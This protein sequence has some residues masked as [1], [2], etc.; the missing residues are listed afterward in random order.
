[1]RKANRLIV[2]IISALWIFPLALQAQT[3]AGAPAEMPPARAIP[4][5]SAEDQFPGGCV[6][7]H[8]NY[9]DLNLDERF[10]TLMAKWARKVDSAVL[11]VA[12]ELG[13]PG[14]K[15]VGVHP[16]VD[17]ALQ[18]IPAACF[19]CHESGAS[20]VVS[21]VPLL[22]RIHLGGG[23]ESVFLSVYQ[24]ECT[25]CHKL[26]GTTGQWRVPSGPEK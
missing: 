15:L 22:H 19:S 21:L 14:V 8:I 20:S 3:D 2:V 10:S 13:G 26:D 7:C 23:S 16:R 12:R 6:D 18:D 5:I 25:H 24:G 4:G 17:A 11:D 1:M 9:A